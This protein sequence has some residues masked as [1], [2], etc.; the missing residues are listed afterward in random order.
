MQAAQATPFF[1]CALCRFKAPYEKFGRTLEEDSTRS[2]KAMQIVWV[3]R[4]FS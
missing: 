1:E 2:G 4:A 3:L